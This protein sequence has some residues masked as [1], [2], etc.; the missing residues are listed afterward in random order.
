MVAET[1]KKS[2]SVAGVDL[3]KDAAPKVQVG[4]QSSR[5][6][7]ILPKSF[8][9]GFGK[10]TK[11]LAYVVLAVVVL[12]GGWLLAKNVFHVGDKVY[13]E[14]AG[15]KIYKKDVEAIK[16]NT[17]GVS[18]HNAA[19]VLA[20]KYLYL[21][22]AKKA[23][24]TVSDQDVEAQYPGA[25]KQKTHNKYVY[26]DDLNL[27]YYN[28]LIAYNKGLYKGK[29]LVANFS[30]Y[31]AF[32]SPYLG[33]QRAT[34]PTIGNKAAI[35]KDKKYAHDFITRLYGQIKGGQITF[36]EAI[37]TEH[38]DPQLGD[39]AYQTLPHSGPFDTSNIFL[40]GT[41]LLEPPSI[42]PKL[43]GMKAGQLSAPFAVRVEN[44]WK[45]PKI[46]TESYYLVVK[47]DYTKG[48]HSGLSFENYLAQAKKQYGYKVNV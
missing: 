20:D 7:G 23:D 37:Q 43:A 13:A 32:Q 4:G 46:T 10:K 18:D 25:A 30:R 1:E 38:A 41:N 27:T 47:M 9:P 42:Q 39:Q 15:H 34:N 5:P 24:I 19:K 33:I 29:V 44:A 6:A 8:N 16:G 31:I 3:G 17:K 48:S 22:M 2:S 45:N 40:P 35:A 21:A 28:K 26:Q 14:A 11:F 36:D 12:G